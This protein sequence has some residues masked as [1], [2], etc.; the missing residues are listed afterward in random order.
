MHT[1]L[2]QERPAILLGHHDIKHDDLR[3][4]LLRQRQSPLGILGTDE[5]IAT[6]G[7]VAPEQLQCVSVVVNDQHHHFLCEGQHDFGNKY[8]SPIPV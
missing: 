3:D 5:A 6:A 4:Q 7:Q 8:L 1:Q 2:S